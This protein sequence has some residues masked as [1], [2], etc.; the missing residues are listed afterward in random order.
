MCL[1]QMWTHK[2]S[3][4]LMTMQPSPDQLVKLRMHG[5]ASIA[6][7]GPCP[8]TDTLQAGARA[9]A[10]CSRSRPITTTLQTGT[11]KPHT[12][13]CLQE[14]SRAEDQRGEHTLSQHPDNLAGLVDHMAM[15][16]HM[17]M[18]N[19]AALAAAQQ[20]AAAEE[21]PGVASGGAGEAAGHQALQQQPGA[22]QNVA[23]SQQVEAS[24]QQQ[25]GAEGQAAGAD[26][27]EEMP[28]ADGAAVQS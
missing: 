27:D 5:L 14:C 13:A 23:V 21:A 4:C 17:A 25:S 26:G 6:C 11:H 28:A 8:A 16:R 7:T 20:A 1:V 15:E 24:S 18:H 22:Q 9:S 10:A 12:H 2:H 3:H 19:S